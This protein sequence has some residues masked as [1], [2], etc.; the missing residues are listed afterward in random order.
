ML[1]LHCRTGLLWSVARATLLWFKDLAL[2]GF[3]SSGTQAQGHMGSA[4]PHST[5]VYPDRDGARVPALVDGFLT[6]GPPGMP[7]WIITKAESHEL[8]VKRLNL[9][10][11]KH[12]IHNTDGTVMGKKWVI[13]LFWTVSDLPFFPDFSFI[14]ERYNYIQLCKVSF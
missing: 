13:F 12:W 8:G 6:T 11:L 3:L 5:C 1:G 4:A 10:Q 9:H 7:P 14:I 2:G